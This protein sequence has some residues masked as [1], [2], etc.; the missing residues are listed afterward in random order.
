MADWGR[1]HRHL[2]KH[3]KVGEAGLAAMGL[4]TLLISWSRDHRTSGFIPD[5]CPLLTEHDEETDQLV[6]SG[7]LDRVP[8]GYTFHD[9]DEH[10][11][12]SR[13]KTTAARL[14]F[15]VFGGRYPES[16]ERSLISKVGELLEEGQEKHVITEAL[17]IW[18]TKPEATV[19][20]LPFLIVD[21]IR[22]NKNNNLDKLIRDALE[23]NDITPLRR[24]GYWFEYPSAPLHLKTAGEVTEFMV[25]AQ[26]EWLLRLQKELDW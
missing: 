18:G 15:D 20:L 22:A 6:R 14:V 26:R 24:F 21:A 17:K 7:L 25:A 5:D 11:G 3:P 19:G 16:V 13:P 1:I 10:N 4:W 23:T 2:H 9:W 8:G 12:D